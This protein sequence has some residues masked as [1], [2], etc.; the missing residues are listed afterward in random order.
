MDPAESR[1][2]SFYGLLIRKRDF[3]EGSSILSV[4][5]RDRGLLEIASYG[6]GNEKS[7]RS[8]A[9]L[10]TGL[11]SGVCYRKD[12]E[13]LPSLKEA[14]CEM[15]FDGITSNYRC[16]T[17]IF[18]IFE[19]L[20]MTLEAGGHQPLAIFNE[21]LL[22]MT[23]INSGGNPESFSIYFIIRF[24]AAEGI[25]PGFDKPDDYSIFMVSL[26]KPGFRLG[27]GSIRLIRDIAASS[28]PEFMENKKISRSVYTNLL[29]FISAVI[30]MHCNREIN[31]L[32][33]IE[34]AMR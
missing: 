3:G 22:T 21:L 4:I 31:S 32:S 10:L 9:L 17:F 23:K 18:L 8:E 15:S 26:E 27:N 11:I 28:G 24:F 13:S 20:S 19:I 5:D 33:M 2:L 14:R 30:R 7:S 16:L 34:V 12:P 1:F 25:L 29:E 6:S